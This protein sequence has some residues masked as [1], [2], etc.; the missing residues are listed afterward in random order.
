MKTNHHWGFNI[1]TEP[2]HQKIRMFSAM[3]I[4]TESNHQNRT[5]SSKNHWGFNIKTE[6]TMNIKQKQAKKSEK[7]KFVQQQTIFRIHAKIK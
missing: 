2:N 5:K 3:K 1:K 7:P 4:K 6:T